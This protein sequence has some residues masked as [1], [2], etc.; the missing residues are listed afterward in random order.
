[1]KVLQVSNFLPPVISGHG[2]LCWELSWR[3]AKK[4]YEVS[5]LSSRI[6]QDAPEYEKARGVSIYRVKSWGVG[7][8]ISSLSV[9]LDKFLELVH[10]YDIVHVHSYLFLMSN[11]VGLVKLL[12]SFPLV[13]QIHGG[14]SLPDP[15]IVGYSK[16]VFKKYFYDP[17]V[18]K[19]MFKVSDWVISTSKRD[20]VL[21][22][23]RMGLDLKRS[24]WIPPAVEPEEFNVKK[25]SNGLT[26][27]YIG[28]LESWKGAALLPHILKTI[29]REIHGVRLIVAG[30]GSLYNFLKG[31]EGKI[32]I[33]IL[34]S[35]RKKEV[36]KLFSKIDLLI[37]PSSIEGIPLVC[38][39]AMASG[40]PVIAFDVGG[41]GEVVVDGVTGCLVKH[42]DLKA[43]ANKIL[44]L[45]KD[46]NLR[47]RM[48]RASQNIA[49][50]R[51]SWRK[52]V[53]EIVNV[54]KI[55]VS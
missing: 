42:G 23:V 33:K 24:S 47:V 32:P 26:L 13:L 29:I 3:L 11:Q 1:M 17:I 18:G 53:K 38:L 9:I 2:I 43:F 7:W 50:R 48:G 27:G 4:G 41:V 8:G 12:K 37:L 6:P 46:E 54:Y 49:R 19:Y 5:I 14:V 39:E 52:V 35:V 22:S 36:P 25:N 44:A 34:G 21:A 40:T 10:G 45:L 15:K 30:Y 20:L 31:F 28:R 16:Y 55:L 51:F